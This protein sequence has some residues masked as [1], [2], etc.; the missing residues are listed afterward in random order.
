[1]K[2]ITKHYLYKKIREKELDGPEQ[3][4]LSVE[5]EGVKHER[6]DVEKLRMEKP[7]CGTGIETL[8]ILSLFSS[9]PLRHRAYPRINMLRCFTRGTTSLLL[10]FL[11]FLLIN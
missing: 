3:E 5:G 6:L 10:S 9:R 1:M 8:P 11:P 4:I 2:Q 7:F